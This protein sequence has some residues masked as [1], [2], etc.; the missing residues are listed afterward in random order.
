MEPKAD[1]DGDRFTVANDCNDDDALVNPDAQEI[2][3]GMDN[4]C[5][6]LIDEEELGEHACTPSSCLEIL[7]NDPSSVSGF[8]DVLD[9]SSAVQR[10]Y[11][12][13]TVDGGGWNHVIF[14]GADYHRE[15]SH[16]S[17]EALGDFE[18]HAKLDDS[19][20]R[21]LARNG[22]REA[23]VM[24]NG[25]TYVLR[26]SDSEW[27]SFSSIGWANVVFDAKDASGTW[28]VD[29][30]DGHV[31]NRGFSTFSDMDGD[32]CPFVFDGIPAYMTTWHTY[33]YSGGCCSGPFAIYVR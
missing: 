26:Y 9:S 19:E 25:N 23:L 6:D 16:L 15:E 4:N 8:Y 31:N 13:M 17:P 1:A 7:R 20:I 22:E 5:D 11:C 27:A 29:V 30:C 21:Y 14:V 3:D 33:E 12:E 24:G 10:H 32:Y 2:C 28:S 18:T